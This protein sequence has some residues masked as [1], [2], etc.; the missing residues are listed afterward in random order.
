MWRF[1]LGVFWLSVLVTLAVISLPKYEV[2]ER[3]ESS[4]TGT[5]ETEGI[6][7][8]WFSP[9]GEMV[10]LGGNESQVIVRVWSGGTSN[11][12]RERT[13]SLPAARDAKPIF[14]VS[15]DAA[16]VAWITPA[17]VHV[18]SLISPTPQSSDAL[19]SGRKIAISAL[20]FTGL[21]QLTAL[22]GD[23]ELEIWDFA[24]KRVI[25]SKHI[26]IAKPVS[27]LANGQYIAAYSSTSGDGVV[28]DT[29][30]G[31]KLSLIEYKK[32][33]RDSLSFTLSP[34]ARLAVG[35]R[36]T[37][38]AEGHSLAAPG[39]VRTL[40]YY[41]R[42]RILVGGDFSGIY[43][44]GPGQDPQQVAAASSG[45]TLLA[46]A[47]SK[48][49]FGNS[50]SLALAS[51]RLV[52][53]RVYK[54]L[55]RPSPLIMLALFVLISPVAIYLC[56]VWFR[57]LLKKAS[58]PP[59]KPASGRPEEGPIPS[60]LVEACQNGDCVLWAGSGLGAQAGLPAWSAFLRELL[61]WAAKSEPALAELSGGMTGATADRIAAAFENREQAL[62]AYLRQRF[63]V[64][65]ELPQAHQ[66]IKQIDF[67]VLISTNLDNLIERT[68]PQSGGRVYTAAKCGDLTHAA[69]HRDFV[70]LKP[71]GDPDEPE[72]IRLGPSQCADAIHNNPSITEFL[73]QVFENRVF[74]F[75]GASLEGIESDLEMMAPQAAVAR[76]HYALVPTIGEGWMTTAGRLRQR[77]RIESLTYSPSTDQHP[78]VV[79]FL[80]KLIEMIQQRSYTQEQ[81]AGE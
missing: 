70:L 18:E 32:Y 11:L 37:L 64:G 58:Q 35:T 14:A 31:D 29:G 68:Y 50:R 56:L 71:F 16:K 55:S 23:G 48:L 13:V 8:L 65:S 46:A 33:P 52:R 38:E 63:R 43:V 80:A 42:N 66:L 17:G 75:L 10:G 6:S 3:L 44:L 36:E 24:G 62:Q 60:A 74:L 61:Q 27:M 45:T 76:K 77:Y 54:G 25:A 53:N 12:I 59:E 19:G 79:E 67:P 7:R 15:S 40:A 34:D 51:D 28:F 47:G 72:T 69:K 30:T 81:V 9:S 20:A 41:D 5:I 39:P 22:Y 49:V 2:V 57:N 26:E 21:G 1:F 4:A 78:E 73:E